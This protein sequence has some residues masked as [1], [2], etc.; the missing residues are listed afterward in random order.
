MAANPYME[1]RQVFQFLDCATRQQDVV[2]RCRGLPLWLAGRATGSAMRD[3]VFCL[4]LVSVVARLEFD[5]EFLHDVPGL[6][7]TARFQPRL[8][9]LRDHFGITRSVY[10]AVDRIRDA[11]NQFVHNATIRVNPGCTRAELP[12]VITTFLRHC[13]HPDDR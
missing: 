5:V 9:I 2:D 7:Q 8:R 6:H 3:Y 1:V 13:D 11:R 10:E 4:M 12:G